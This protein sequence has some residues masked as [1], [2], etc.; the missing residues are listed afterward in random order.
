MTA[1]KTVVFLI[2]VPGTV[3]GWVPYWISRWRG[4]LPGVELGG[5]RH[6]GWL[7]VIPGVAALLWSMFEFV[8]KGQ[9]T[10]APFD[11]PKRFVATGLYQFVRNPMYVGVL[12][13]V[14]GQA[15][16]YESLNVLAYA[17]AVWSVVHAFVV[18]YEEPTLR[19]L[20]GDEYLNCCRV[21]PRWI[22]R[23]QAAKRT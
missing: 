13:A 7:L 21:V 5:W 9:G 18:F 16:L 23:I 4:G 8:T 1:L 20:F 19:R 3:A 2:L 12:V 15:M 14:V 17:A 22:P 6:V 11:P 10:P